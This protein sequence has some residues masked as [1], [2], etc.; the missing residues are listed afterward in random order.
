[1]QGKL[2]DTQCLMKRADQLGNCVPTEGAI[3]VSDAASHNTASRGCGRSSGLEGMFACRGIFKR[4]PA[5]IPAPGSQSSAV[6]HS[7]WPFVLDPDRRAPADE[8]WLDAN[9]R[10]FSFFFPFLLWVGDTFITKMQ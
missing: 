4:V 8:E 1:M 2:T 9:R 7:S 10:C 5:A 3:T 6:G